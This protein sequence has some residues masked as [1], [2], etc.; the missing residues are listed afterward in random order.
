[1]LGY[2]FDQN[3]T[4]PQ[5]EKNILPQ[6]S[7][8]LSQ[9]IIH[10]CEYFI[11]LGMSNGARFERP[12]GPQAK[13]ALTNMLR[14]RNPPNS[15]YLNTM[16]QPNIPPHNFQGIQRQFLR[17]YFLQLNVCLVQCEERIH[18]INW[19]HKY[20]FFFSLFLPD[21]KLGLSII[22]SHQVSSPVQIP[23]F[24]DLVLILVLDNNRCLQTCRKVNLNII[25]NILEGCTNC[26]L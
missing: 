25:L 22:C 9:Q 3:S 8:F 23:C 7:Y 19:L 17:Y 18:T 13:Q 2:S 10:W 26:A 5:I 12:P 15:Q 21:N 6:F 11:F 20:S 16:Q 1:M 24:L 14:Q 4:L